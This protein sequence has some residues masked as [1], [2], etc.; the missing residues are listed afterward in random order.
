MAASTI[1]SRI[2]RAAMERNETLADIAQHAQISR[3]AMSRIVH[4]KIASPKAT[5]IRDVA[6]YLRVSSDYLLGLTEEMEP[7]GVAHD[8][9][10]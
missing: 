6:E 5:V 7:W 1:G 4:G 9:D 10:D 3:N 2:R 8:R